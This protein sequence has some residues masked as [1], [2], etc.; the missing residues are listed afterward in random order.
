MKLG[1]FTVLF[2][3]KNLEEMLDYV[4]NA[5]LDAV[6]IGTGGYPGDAHLKLDVLLNSETE[7]QT[8]LE[9]VNSRGLTISALSCHGNPVSPDEAFRK[10]SHETLV[11]TI[12]LAGLLNIPV[13]NTFSGTPGDS[14][15]GKYPNWPV[16]PWPE[17]YSTVLKW[18]WEEKTRA[19]LERNK[20]DCRRK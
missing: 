3:D 7:R 6:E 8:F 20:H 12:K 18:Q 1:V 16:T 15:D 9:K 14:E 5:G 4:K 11:K 19:L 13:V 17:E 2:A 10:D